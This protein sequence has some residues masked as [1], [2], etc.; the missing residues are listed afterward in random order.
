[1]EIEYKLNQ[2]VSLEQFLA[3]LKTSTLEER[4][5]IE[6]LSCMQGMLDNANLTYTAWLDGKLIG[7]ARC[8]TD[9]HYC[10]YLSDLAVDQ[11]VQQTG[12][13]KKL[14]DLCA[15]HTPESCKLVLL[16]SPAANAYYPKI[17]ME[18]N[19]RCWMLKG[20]NKIL[21]ETS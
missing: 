19:D 13:G 9:F 18:N 8:L 4:R 14:V 15:K 12:I 11:T 20:T 6:D 2:P 16:A 3:L 21:E 5:P 10:T 7:I 17:G 1:M